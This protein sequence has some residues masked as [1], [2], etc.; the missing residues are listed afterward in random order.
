MSQP[1]AL[2]VGF[3]GLGTMGRP[4]A[5]NL[6][7]AGFSLVVR[8]LEPTRE[9]AF[10]DEFRAA[11]A[12]TVESFGATTVIV[13]MLPDGVAV[14]DALL[15]RGVAAVL[16]PGA[17]VIDMSSSSPSSTREL[18][19]ALSA[20]GVALV[21]APVSGGRAKATDGT[22]SVMLGADDDAAAARVTP[23]LQAMSARI[24]RVGG[25]GSGH[26]V[27][28]LNNY[29]LAAGF[30]A[31]S[32]AM[33]IAE[34]YGLELSVLF[35]VLS[36]SSGRNIATDSILP[37]Q[38]LTRR[39]AEGFPFRLLCKD[40]GIAEDLARELDVEAPLCAVVTKR[41]RDAAEELGWDED[42]TR[43]VEM[44]ERRADVDHWGRHGDH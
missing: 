23:V 12:D 28:A 18:G 16:P 7:R 19:A 38:V 43:A 9:T 20:R 26:T 29:L 36:A 41:L 1:S 15:G 21:D 3:I 33:I 39:F 17:V 30:S 11:T 5:A 10:A 2:N 6:A 25:L 32:E 35:E 37:S 24:F 14:R 34:K 42:Y 13:T 22:L 27:K 44:W 40:V 8:D 31:A 4:M